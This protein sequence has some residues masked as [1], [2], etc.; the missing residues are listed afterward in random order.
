MAIRRRISRASGRGARFALLAVAWVVAFTVARAQHAEPAPDPRSPGLVVLVSGSWAFPEDEARRL[1]ADPQRVVG[2]AVAPRAA[3]AVDP[4]ASLGAPTR[5]TVLDLEREGA[6]DDEALAERVRTARCVVLAEGTWVAWWTVLEPNQKSTALGR[7]LREAHRAGAT[8]VG[9]DT[10]GSYLGAWSLVSRAQIQ[11]P[12]RDP[13]DL[14]PDVISSS[15]ALAPGFCFDRAQDGRASP[16][17][18][19]DRLANSVADAGVWLEGDVAW[20]HD[21]ARDDVRVVARGGRAF[22]FDAAAG[23][24]TR[25]ALRAARWT[26][27]E[28]GAR[29]DVRARAITLTAPRPD[30]PRIEPGT[31]PAAPDPSAATQSTWAFASP[32]LLRA[33]GALEFPAGRFAFMPAD[34][35]ASGRFDW[36][37]TPRVR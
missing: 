37:P 20:I 25:G 32:D 2:V 34:A 7:A 5:F 3:D 30:T 36:D 13:H 4:F 9:L 14:V 23:R 22:V 12:A 28:D 16:A 33:G 11:R 8:I 10:A 6:G 18:L 17:A 1:C 27:L 24:R 26:V 21:A 15:F 29:F 35:P 19:V 31:G